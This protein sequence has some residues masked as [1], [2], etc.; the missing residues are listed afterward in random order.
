LQILNT[1]VCRVLV[2]VM[3]NFVR[4]EEAPEMFLDDEPVAIDVSLLPI[5]VRMVWGVNQNASVT[6]CDYAASPVWV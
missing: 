1:V 4:G 6:V 2:D 5:R 3:D